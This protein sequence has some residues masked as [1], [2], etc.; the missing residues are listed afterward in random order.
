VT[1]SELDVSGAE[2]DV[3]DAVASADGAGEAEGEQG[4]G[5]WEP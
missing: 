1:G 2:L 4:A 5:R 3:S